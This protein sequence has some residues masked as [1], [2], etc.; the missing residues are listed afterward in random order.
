MDVAN[1]RAIERAIDTEL[2]N[3]EWSERL[4]LLQQH[5]I[6]TEVGQQQIVFPSRWVG[7]IMLVR[8]SQVLTL[9]C[10][11]SLVLGVTHHQGSMVPLISSSIFLSVFPSENHD[12]SVRSAFTE[13]LHAVRLNQSAG[14]LA[15][16]GIVVDRVIGNVSEAQVVSETTRW[17]FQLQDVPDHV[18][19]LRR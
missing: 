9:P 16:V 5:F 12:Q 2:L 1:E 15:G 17:Q 8:R 10:Y 11:S 4:P 18:W 14:K 19:Q 6:L 7:E 3:A 13:I